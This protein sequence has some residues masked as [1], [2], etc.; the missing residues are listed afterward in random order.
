MFSN[1]GSFLHGV[2]NCDVADTL[3]RSWQSWMCVYLFNTK[4]S[5]VDATVKYD[6]NNISGLV[7]LAD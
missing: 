3:T 6:Y 2:Y 4:Y 7:F 1:M 5:G